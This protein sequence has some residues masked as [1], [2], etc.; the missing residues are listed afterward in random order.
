MPSIPTTRESLRVSIVRIQRSLALLAGGVLFGIPTPRAAAALALDETFRPHVVA[1]PDWDLSFNN[2][3]ILTGFS[4]GRIL[5]SG[6]FS[7]VN[8]Q[9][10]AGFAMF[11]TDGAF[12]ADAPPPPID[13]SQIIHVLPDGRMVIVT[14]ESDTSTVLRR[15]HPDYTLDGGLA[16]ATPAGQGRVRRAWPLPD[17]RMLLDGDFQLLN[18][19]DRRWVA[20]LA[21]DGSVDTTFQAARFYTAILAVE[22]G[23]GALVSDAYIL[24]PGKG[25]RR[26][27]ADGAEDTAF[28]VVDVDPLQVWGAARRADGSYLVWGRFSTIDGQ[29]RRGY[30]RVL[31]DGTLADDFTGLP[32]DHDIVDLREMAD[33][34]V[35]LVGLRPSLGTAFAGT[36]PATGGAPAITSIPLTTFGNATPRIHIQPDGSVLFAGNVSALGGHP[37][38]QIAR[39]HADNTVDTAF[40][41]SL[42]YAGWIDGLARGPGGRLAVFGELG[43]DAGG[44]RRQLA[45]LE[46]DGSID[47]LF[48][49]G[50]VGANQ[51]RDI[52]MLPDGSV[53][54]AA[55]WQAAVIGGS[56]NG[57]RRFLP[58]G[59]RDAAFEARFT[60][61]PGTLAVTA[62]GRLL[63]QGR[64]LNDAR[65]NDL[66]L[67][68]LN[69]DLSV[70]TAF[71]VI[72]A[73]TREVA[74]LTD[75]SILVIGDVTDSDQATRSGFVRLDADGVIDPAFAPPAVP[76]GPTRVT[77][78]PDGRIV[79][80]GDF[81]TI[82]GV[83]RKH[84]ARLEADGGVDPTFVPPD[85]ASTAGSTRIDA[86][87]VLADGSVIV[88]GPYV[89]AG[90]QVADVVARLHADGSLDPTLNH[91]FGGHAYTPH[92]RGLVGDGSG[93]VYAGGS[94]AELNGPR[95][96]L[97]RF[98][99]HAFHV[100]ADP[101]HVRLPDGG[102][103]VLTARVPGVDD[104]TYQ[105]RRD[106]V[107]LPGE[108]RA[109]LALADFTA[110]DAGT[111]DVAVSAG[112]ATVVSEPIVVERSTTTEVTLLAPLAFSGPG[113]IGGVTVS[114]PTGTAWTVGPLP[115]WVQASAMNGAG[116]ATVT[117][118]LAPN[119]SGDMRSADIVVAGRT[120][121]LT[122]RATS[123]R[124]VNVSSRGHAGTGENLMI[125]GFVTSGADPLGILCRGVGPGLVRFGVGTVLPDPEL[126]LF[127]GAN[128]IG[129]NADWHD[130]GARDAV[131]A[132][133]QPVGAFALED[134][135]HDAALLATPPPGR[136]TA[137]V[138]DPE[139]ASG[140]ALAEFYDRGTEASVDRVLNISTR[141]RAGSGENVLIAGFIISGSAPK[142]VLIRGVGPGLL[143]HDVQDVLPDPRLR[144]VLNGQTIL[145]NEDWSLTRAAS[146]TAAAGASVQAFALE[147]GGRDAALVAT[148]PP[149]AYTVVVSGGEGV[150]LAEVYDLE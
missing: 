62:D 54:V 107:D 82:G 77:A 109:G 123:S 139:G 136:Y 104:A 11:D 8:G 138:F 45:I 35:R 115:A 112:G 36:V 140:V 76:S 12:V 10:R 58:D 141:A 75:G 148:L 130:A 5:A 33:G 15:M 52:A 63:L 137:H 125:V 100:F 17:G 20:R 72:A 73:T 2:I 133:G 69:H 37:V 121:H 32:A 60:Y 48:R 105:W 131:L 74:P 26:L 4:D 134:G 68:R 16:V 118:S 66:R 117:L 65:G 59:S 102:G 95:T 81:T 31:A 23:G 143:A 94:F 14:V 135:S 64:D 13:L 55:F 120:L 30:G 145:E 113:G 40:A 85:F 142:Q 127:A 19:V 114:A 110:G 150:A 7:V 116:S 111:Y 46:P 24:S 126:V 25:L 103:T 96:S 132:A 49:P 3:Q 149:G 18:G 78:A 6:A 56:T 128:E 61:V 144:V 71:D 92:A 119:A 39:L 41:A 43:R 101:S 27:L 79:V 84:I 98:R 129:R 99:A 90:L 1:T 50:H 34:S 38:D 29:L 70:D 80:T 124:L 106:G 51:I 28:G 146:F 44:V 67:T 93:G 83:A 21:A 89:T 22:P 86:A 147:P 9:Y 87:S 53:V 57:L 97:V 108:D 42:G 88:S 47:P 122:Q 91:P